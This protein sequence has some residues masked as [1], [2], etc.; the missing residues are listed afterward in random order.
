MFSQSLRGSNHETGG[1]DVQFSAGLISDTECSDIVRVED[2]SMLGE[3]GGN[4]RD[5]DDQ[6]EGGGDELEDSEESDHEPVEP[7]LD[8]GGEWHPFRNRVTAQLVLLYHGSHR[9][10][11]DLVTFRSFMTILKVRN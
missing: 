10:N 6:S 9:R 1:S 5:L 3:V 4:I 8:P 7:D 11:L 2:V